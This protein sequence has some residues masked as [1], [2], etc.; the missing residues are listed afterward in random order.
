MRTTA[1]LLILLAAPAFA[2][3]SAIDESALRF[4]ADVEE[5]V[6]NRIIVAY[7]R[8]RGQLTK[9]GR[10]NA[11]LA[12]RRRKNPR[13]GKLQR[14]QNQLRRKIEDARKKAVAAMQAAG[15]TDALLAQVRAM[16]HG[17]AREQRI[18]H[19]RVLEAPGLTTRQRALLEPLVHSV[20]G[21]LVALERSQNRVGQT[22]K[23]EDRKVGQQATAR[24][25]EQFRATERRFWHVVYYVLT[26]EQMR[27]VR[28]RL[29]QRYRRISQ[30]RESMI[31]LPG[32]TP[33]Q[34]TR[35]IA[36]F[37]EHESEITADMAA[38]RLLGIKL[39]DKKLTR[40]QRQQ[41]NRERGDC[42]RRMGA[43]NNRLR[44]GLYAI[45]DDEQKA[46]YESLPPMLNIGERGRPPWGYTAKMAIDAETRRK[47]QA[48]Q[49]AAGS[50]IRDAQRESNK[51]MAA[52]GMGGGARAEL[53]PESPQAMGMNMMRQNQRG[54]ATD[55]L[56]E[57]GADL[58]LEI[59]APH[60]VL[61]W[62][63]GD[64]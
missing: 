59:L 40:E 12:E 45:L 41:I 26:P 3:G 50:Q 10:D 55:I 43:A 63:A 22:F 13:D 6:R 33:S 11:K 44:E 28:P 17:P 47:I 1:L 19:L 24:I 20:N 53:G 25:R 9:L 2:G 64:L 38:V 27:A 42:Y 7:R 18:N 35:V 62:V 49:R 54:R 61:R 36:R 14:E 29:T 5:P 57:A 48:L 60:Q 52:M 51:A 4:L 58:M 32:M 23:A 56:R 34:G 16:P 30:P 8:A 37:A 21:S 39:R 31:A 46:A 15:L